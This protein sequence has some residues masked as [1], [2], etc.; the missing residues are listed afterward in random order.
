MLVHRKEI[1]IMSSNKKLSKYVKL[2][3]CG[4]L[5]NCIQWPNSHILIL[6]W[7]KNRWWIVNCCLA[8]GEDCVFRWIKYDMKS[9]GMPQIEHLDAFIVGL[10]QVIWFRRTQGCCRTVWE[11]RW[12]GMSYLAQ[13]CHLRSQC[14][15]SMRLRVM[16][17]SIFSGV[18]Q[19]DWST[20]RGPLKVTSAFL[21]GKKNEFLGSRSMLWMLAGLPVHFIQIGIFYF[22]CV[23]KVKYIK[24]KPSLSS[25]IIFRQFF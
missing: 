19:P 11:E 5:L 18:S 14:T 9:I 16:V 8:S 22:A 21:A 17:I 13:D 24:L 10:H 7:I 12:E 3:W 1:V 23:F 2:R 20:T 25:L 15:L 6:N 4:V